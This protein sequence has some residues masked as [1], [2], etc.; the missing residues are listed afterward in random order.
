[1]NLL[2]ISLGLSLVVIL[3]CKQRDASITNAEGDG[4]CQLVDQNDFDDPVAKVASTACNK[5]IEKMFYDA[6]CIS[7]GRS[8]V[9]EKDFGH[10]A[11]KIDLFQCPFGGIDP[12]TP[13]AIL[14]PGGAPPGNGPLP[15]LVLFSHP[16]ELLTL[17]PKRSYLNFYKLEES[18][19]NFKGNSFSPN[20]ECRKCH[21]MGG[22]VMKEL[23][24]PW[25]NW[26]SENPLS[27]QPSSNLQHLGVDMNGEK[28]R[29]FDPA[30]MES[31]VRSSASMVAMARKRGLS[32]GNV[33]F[34]NETLRD[35]LK[36]LFCTVEINLLTQKA[37]Q[38]P[39]PED[40]NPTDFTVSALY[41]DSLALQGMTGDLRFAK[42]PPT[43]KIKEFFT[44]NN[45]K[46]DNFFQVVPGE[47]GTQA[48]TLMSY[49]VPMGPQDRA[50][51]EMKLFAAG[52][53]F[54]YPNP[55]F[56]KRRC[57]L[58][59]YIPSTPM[60]ELKTPEDITKQVV[61]SLTKAGTSDAKEFIKL[62][63]DA[64]NDPNPEVI[65]QEIGRRSA[66]LIEEC[67]KPGSALQDVS[68]IYR[69]Y[70]AKLV[71]ILQGKPLKYFD[72]I[73][74]VEHFASRENSPSKMFPEYQEIIDGKY[75]ADEGLG[76]NEK[77]E[78]VEF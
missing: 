54:D 72:R 36:P 58:W 8:L 3:S 55:I 61:H 17:D 37:G 12:N 5:N 49:G 34:S 73:H 63:N 19:L 31:L 21:V 14:P 26:S 35:V 52:K 48:M 59:K 68:K 77:C 4:P 53:S 71:P 44:A 15:S 6:G 40:F 11:R 65:T 50:L 64:P 76:L 78:L 9:A 74:V 10:Q 70:R 75:A 20:N 67:N 45:I 47:G 60:T 33:L 66:A 39:G 24:V 22:M 1:M 43:E 41:L 16:N 30:I 7:A 69:L 38:G 23:T 27:G 29:A 51:I 28:L 42:T 25:R 62:I 18:S 2:S 46:S 57:D 32:E 56:S 13:G